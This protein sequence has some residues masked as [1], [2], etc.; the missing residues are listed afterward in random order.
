MNADEL[1][2]HLDGLHC[3]VNE[4]G[5][6]PRPAHIDSYGTVFEF[7]LI[8]AELVKLKDINSRAEWEKVADYLTCQPCAIGSKLLGLIVKRV[9]LNTMQAYRIVDELCCTETYKDNLAEANKEAL[10]IQG[11]L[12]DNKTNEVLR[13]YT[14]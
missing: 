10:N 11:V 3:F 13:D 2:D 9:I 5:G 12:F 4:M 1:V 14:C 7:K 8:E 6:T